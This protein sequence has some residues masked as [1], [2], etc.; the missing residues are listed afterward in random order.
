M[1]ASGYTYDQG[2]HSERARLAGIE[3]LW[4]PGTQALLTAGGAVP[5]ARVLEAGA[6]GGSVVAWLAEQV[7]S[8][9]RV[10]AVDLDVRFVEPLRSDVV[11]VRQADLV[12][13]DL[14]E[15]AFDLVHTRMVLEHIPER[16][17]VL[18]HLVRA[19]RPGGTLV[20]EDY[21]WTAFGFDS[22]DDTEN[23]AA[24]AILGLMAMAGFDRE[25][26]RTLVGALGERGLTDVRGEGRSLVIDD[27]HPGFDFFRLSFE[28]LAPTAVEAGLM[29]AEDAAVVGER[30]RE[31][32]RRIITPTL[33]AAVGR[34]P[35]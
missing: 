10:L 28:Q 2:W 7:G 33:V 19:L 6:G 25:Y 27:T 24:E 21:D 22:A 32:G 9:G 23:R 20:V 4:D 3:A 13:G 29:T 14:P 11:E 17:Q 16:G 31:G 30:F 12:A 8:A 15:A 34:A 5:G 1:T 18:D 26:G 35:Q